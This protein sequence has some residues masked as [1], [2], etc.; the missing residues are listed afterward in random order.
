MLRPLDTGAEGDAGADAVLGAPTALLEE[1]D[2]ALETLR[3]LATALENRFFRPSE[4]AS[5][6]GIDDV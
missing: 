3:E 2:A 1:A 5:R 6:W 4:S